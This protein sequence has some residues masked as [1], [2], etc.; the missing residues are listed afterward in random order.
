MLRYP[1][2]AAAMCASVFS[3]PAIAATALFDFEGLT[4]TSIGSSHPGA[5]TSLVLTS[6]G[7]TATINRPSSTFDVV[8]TTTFRD[9]FPSSFGTRSLDPFSAETSN[10]PFIIDFSTSVNSVS[11][12]AGDF[13]DDSDIVTLALYSGFGATGA[14]VGSASFSYEAS[15]FPTIATLQAT[16]I[17]TALSARI[18]GGSTDFPNSLYYDNLSVEFTPEGAVPE[19]ATWAMM[20][21]GVGMVGG[22]MRR[23]RATNLRVTYA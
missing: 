5:L 1:V 17:S 8:D 16:G 21:G 7:L 15:A 2:I 20:I 10:T 4:S 18:Q 22:M 11:F 6:S 14:I 13:G 12:D 23:R 19:P 3:G 9:A